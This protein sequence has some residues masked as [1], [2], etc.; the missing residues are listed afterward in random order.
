MSYP[1]QLVRIYNICKEKASESKT[2]ESYV[3]EDFPWHKPNEF[4]AQADYLKDKGILKVHLQESRKLH[5]L[6]LTALKAEI[7]RLKT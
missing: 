3:F 7:E 5:E 2:P 4:A 1:F 6:D